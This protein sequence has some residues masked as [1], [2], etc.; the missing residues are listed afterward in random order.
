VCAR[1]PVARGTP[2]YDRIRE[3]CIQEL[4]G[5]RNQ[6]GGY[7]I[8]K[9][10]PRAAAEAVTGR[11]L[12]PDLDSAVLLSNGAS[13]IVSPYGVTSWP[14]VLELL[15][16]SGP[17]EIIR[18]VRQ[19]EVRGEASPDVAA[20]DDATVAHCLFPER[21]GGHQTRPLDRSRSTG[22]C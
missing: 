8:A 6:H 20:P 7:W 9:D 2:G 21:R 22:A 11:R 3:S 5:R 15:G 19:A 14:G 13:R 17:A 16:A 12:L 4:R 1:R 10:D 18:R